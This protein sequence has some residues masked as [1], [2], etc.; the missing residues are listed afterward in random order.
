MPSQGRP[1]E[2]I[3]ERQRVILDLP[4]ELVRALDLVAKSGRADYIIALLGAQKEIQAVLKKEVPAG[5]YDLAG[6]PLTGG[7]QPDED[8]WVPVEKPD[9]SMCPAIK[10]SVGLDGV[11]RFYRG[12]VGHYGFCKVREDDVSGESLRDIE[13]GFTQSYPDADFSAWMPL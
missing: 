10:I 13:R 11:R 1:K 2:T 9:E 7:P 4:P 5:F 3:S 12:Y 6:V 8:V